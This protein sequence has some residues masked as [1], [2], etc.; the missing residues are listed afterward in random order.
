MNEF[1]Y[2]KTVK[3]PVCEKNFEVAKL[4][5]K[6][7]RVIARDTDYCTHYEGLNPL[8]YD[9]WVCEHCG[10]AAQSEK[11]EEISGRDSKMIF[12]KLEPKW[13]KRKYNGERTVDV[14]IETYK[15]A[16]LNLQIRQ[17]KPSEFARIC[18]RIGWL[19]RFKE[20]TEKEME[21]LKHAVKYYDDTYQREKFPVDKLDEYTCLYMIGELNRR[22]GNLDA[23]VIWLGRLLSLPNARKNPNLIE[24]AREQFQLVKDS[25]SKK[26]A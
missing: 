2:K 21:F 13:G 11:Y 14:A 12:E 26:E 22:I 3:C 25:L 9:I 4:K 16:L 19:Y 24:V 20:D 6:G 23:A 1:L 8:F 10:Y 15:L 18:L 17:A 7:L 5:I